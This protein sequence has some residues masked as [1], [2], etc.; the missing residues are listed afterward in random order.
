M[1]GKQKKTSLLGKLVGKGRDN[2]DGGKKSKKVRQSV[3]T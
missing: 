1:S 3:I 2:D